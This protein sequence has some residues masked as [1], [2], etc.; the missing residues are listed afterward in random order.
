MRYHKVGIFKTSLLVPFLIFLSITFVGCVSIKTFVPQGGQEGSEIEI[1]GSGFSNDTAGNK[2][3]FGE[4]EAEVL[5]ASENILRV[6]VPGGVVRSKIKVSRGLF[7]RD[8]SKTEFIPLPDYIQYKQFQSTILGIRQGYWIMYPPSFHEEG[9]KFP[10]IYALHG[11]NFSRNPISASV[12]DVLEELGL[13][14]LG[15]TNEHAWVLSITGPGFYLPYIAYSLMESN[16]VDEFRATL[17]SQLN[18]VAGPTELGNVNGVVDSIVYYLPT[19]PDSWVSD[20]DDMVIVMPDGDNSWYTDRRGP[21]GGR[22]PDNLGTEPS[23]PTPSSVN[24]AGR[25]DLHV[26]GW[27]EKYLMQEFID[28]VETTDIGMDKLAAE[29]KRRFLMGISMGGFGSLKLALRHPDKYIGVA[30]ISASPCITSNDIQAKNLLIPEF[31]D[32]FGS[33]PMLFGATLQELEANVH[34]DEDYIA[35]NNPME[36]ID[37]FADISLHF[38]IEIGENDPISMIGGDVMIC[39]QNFLTALAPKALSVQGGI[40]PAASNTEPSNGNAAHSPAFMR[41]RLG[42]T[43]KLFSDVYEE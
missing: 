43:L 23:F 36:L 8:E 19:N 7:N 20:M 4:L 29:E 21:P 34:L 22:N 40:V 5:G 9:K 14:N 39:I 16:T 11:Y 32:V 28:Y 18:A 35:A 24:P 38:L 10:V 25:F 42:G 31:I 41:T 30:A 6:R 33:A 12:G 1:I 15:E 27:Y 3:T 13:T 37:T 26:T 17:A 2:V